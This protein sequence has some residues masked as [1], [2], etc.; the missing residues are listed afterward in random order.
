MAPDSVVPHLRYLNDA[1]HLLSIES[2]AVSAHLLSQYN[3]LTFEGELNPSDARKRS[4]CGACGNIMIPGWTCHVRRKGEES[5]RS[6]RGP[7]TKGPK[8]ESR[9]AAPGPAL[10]TDKV[11]MKVEYECRLC[12]R[13]TRQILPKKPPLKRPARLAALSSVPSRLMASPSTL[14]RNSDLDAAKPIPANASS[15]KRAKARKQGGLQALLAKKKEEGEQVGD[16]GL[17]LM[18]LM[19]KT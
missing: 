13:T 3:K 7:P 2:P 15:K 4:V 10:Q 12:G 6:L 16:F 18:D 8:S 11:E 19:K 17:D 14:T 9:G 5:R 1:A